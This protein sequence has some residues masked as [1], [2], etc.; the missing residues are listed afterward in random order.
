[1]IPSSEPA[2][3]ADPTAPRAGP[4]S[5][6][7]F[8]W[9][10]I[11]R[12]FLVIV[13]GVLVALGAQ[14]WWEGRQDREHELQ[15]KR[16]LQADLGEQARRLERAIAE[17]SLASAAAGRLLYILH[18]GEPVSADSFVALL[19]SAGRA[20]DFQPVG[21]TYGA[22]LG[23][24]DL[25]LIRPD[26]VR[27]LITS[28]AGTI[29]SERRRLEQ[30]RAMVLDAVPGLA[31]ALPA[32]RTVFTEGLDPSRVDVHQARSDAEL[33]VVLFTLQAAAINR[34]NGLRRAREANERLRRAL[35]D[36]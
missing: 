2:P 24:G 28:Y 12:E 30:L 29:E 25:R 20:S 5:P 11:L 21:G 13:A 34:L 15:Y 4:P 16:Q 35:E 10:P 31:R 7:R 17:D 33:P 6:R 22:L 9:M 8:H 23:T 26:S 14:A 19:G 1:M 3:T 36:A 18:H 32:M 27:G